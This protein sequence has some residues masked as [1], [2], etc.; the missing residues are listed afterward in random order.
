MKPTPLTTL[1]IALFIGCATAHADWT[2]NLY[3]NTDVGAAFVPDVTT[4]DHGVDDTGPFRSK[5]RFQLDPGVRA[6]L[7]LGYNLNQ[8]WAVELEAGGIWNQNHLSSNEQ[9]YQI[10]VLLKACYQIPLGQSWKVC[11]GAGAGAVTAIDDLPGNTYTDTTWGY[12]GDAAIKY[13][14]SSNA[15]IGLGYK[16]LGADSYS[17]DAHHSTASMSSPIVIHSTTDT[18]YTHAVLLSFTWKF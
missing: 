15:E 6:D 11:L 7:S 18:F 14:L 16:F 3:L 4:H 12:E 2:D 5:G 13:E 10:P 8:S 17:F 1:G 9:F